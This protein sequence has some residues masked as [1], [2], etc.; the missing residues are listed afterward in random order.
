MGDYTELLEEGLKD[1]IF[2]VNEINTHT[3]YIID[4]NN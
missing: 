4:K 3:D 1:M 2:E